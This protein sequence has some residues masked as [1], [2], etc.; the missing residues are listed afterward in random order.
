MN[1]K[2]ILELRLALAAVAVLILAFFAARAAWLDATSP[3]GS[4][5]PPT[6]TSDAKAAARAMKFSQ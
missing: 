3:E 5:Q 4:R 2:E 6:A 1:E